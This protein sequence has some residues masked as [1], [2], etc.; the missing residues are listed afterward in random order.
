MHWSQLLASGQKNSKSLRY[1]TIFHRYLLIISSKIVVN[2]ELPAGKGPLQWNR[3]KFIFRSQNGFIK[4]RPWSK[5]VIVNWN[6]LQTPPKPCK[7]EYFLVFPS[8]SFNVSFKVCEIGPVK[9]HMS[10]PSKYDFTAGF[11][12]CS[13]LTSAGVRSSAL[14][15]Y[16]D[17]LMD[18]TGDGADWYRWEL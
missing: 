16:T 15:L 13:W 6:P 10:D 18:D 2:N 9:C 1:S 11:C 12:D 14:W 4:S 3:T 17:W 8:N 5:F 7:P